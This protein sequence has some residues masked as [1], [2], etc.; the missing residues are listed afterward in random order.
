[1][2]SNRRESPKKSEKAVET[3]HQRRF[4]SHH[5]PSKMSNLIDNIL[6]VLPIYRFDVGICAKSRWVKESAQYLI[7]GFVLMDSE[8]FQSFQCLF[9]DM[10]VRPSEFQ[11][12]CSRSQQFRIVIKQLVDNPIH[13]STVIS[14]PFKQSAL[15]WFS[16]WYCLHRISFISHPI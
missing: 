5:F 16:D 12:I 15:C 11:F 10:D 4:S 2:I 9:R 7:V 1:M 3:I 8:R 14:N 13:R 6:F